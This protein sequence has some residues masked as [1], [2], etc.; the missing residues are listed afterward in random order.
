MKWIKTFIKVFLIRQ[1]HILFL[2]Q[3]WWKVLIHFK[4][5]LLYNIGYVLVLFLNLYIWTLVSQ[6]AGYWPIRFS[7]PCIR[8][9]P[10]LLYLWS[11]WT[12]RHN[13]ALHSV[14]HQFDFYFVVF[15]CFITLIFKIPNHV[16]IFTFW[17]NIYQNPILGMMSTRRGS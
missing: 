14:H 12:A 2:G 6:A 8:P 9:R 5:W 4:C 13:S 11:A 7:A 1:E 16:N 15:S 10:F 17:G 3:L